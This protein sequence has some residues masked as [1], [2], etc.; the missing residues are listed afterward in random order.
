MTNQELLSKTITNLRFP[1]IV[2]IVFI[3]FSL[4]DG[5]DMGGEKYGLDNPGW[6]FFI[7][8]LVSEV[9]ARIGV[10]LFFI[11]SGFLFFYNKDFDMTVYKRKLWVRAR[12]L[13]LP[14]LLWNL[15]AIVWQLKSFVPVVSSFCAPVDVQV[16][17]VRILS[18]FFCNDY[19][20][21]I[22]V[23]AEAPGVVSSYYPI[24]VPLWF[25]R[26][27]MIMVV[28]TPVI[29]WLIKR[30]GAWVMALMGVLWFCEPVTSRLGVFAV[31]M[32]N[33]LFF[34]SLG[35]YF[36]I[37]KLDFVQVFRRGK[38]AP[39][40]YI[41][42]AVIDALTKGMS[43]NGYINSVGIV[44]GVVAA[45][46]IVSRLVEL[47]KECKQPLL[48]ESSFFIYA[49]HGIFIDDVGKFLFK[50]LHIPDNNPFAML[51]LYFSVPIIVI[52]VSLALYILMK[53]YIPSVLKLFT[54]GR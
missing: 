47:G 23:G 5:L 18:T 11:I 42:I 28:I 31:E 4:S 1:L 54:G 44:F 50:M 30:M 41:V 33:A 37:S 2:G 35:A 9:F 3:H 22:F 20:Y 8:N 6:Y 16:S 21:G 17:F 34:F 46:V 27:L 15:V 40:V 29:Y 48:S 53:R 26:D 12:T 51:A 36:S 52:L 32:S 49:L 25:L 14:Y 39:F 24:D 43:F 45:V 38:F 13:L 19:N 7:V 10:P